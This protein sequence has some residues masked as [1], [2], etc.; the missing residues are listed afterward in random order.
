MDRRDLELD[1]DMR[2]YWQGRRGII[3]DATGTYRAE[4][5]TWLLLSK[6]KVLAVGKKYILRVEEV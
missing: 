2:V 4:N 6:S 5:S 3:K 1:G